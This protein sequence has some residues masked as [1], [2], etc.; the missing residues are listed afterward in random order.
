MSVLSQDTEKPTP[1]PCL[2]PR[3]RKMRHLEGNA[4]RVLSQDTDKTRA[5]LEV[6]S[7]I[8]SI[9]DA[10]GSVRGCMCVYTH[11][12]THTARGMLDVIQDVYEYIFTEI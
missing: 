12:P 1:Y 11:T 5:K 7:C 10:D 8:L 6:L 3:H 4:T 2:V 9:F